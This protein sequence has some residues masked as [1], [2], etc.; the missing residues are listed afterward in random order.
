MGRPIK[1]GLVLG[2]Y[3]AAWLVAG[4]AVY[5]RQLNTQDA[6]AQPSAGMYAFGDLL[7]FL[8]VFGTLQLVPTGLA[9][10]FLRRWG[11]FWTVFSLAA[12]ALAMTG[13]VATLAVAMAS[14]QPPRSLCGAAAAFGVLRMLAAPLLASVLVLATLIAPAGRPRWGLWAATLIEVAGRNVFLL[15]LVRLAVC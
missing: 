14:T 7:L 15:P 13:L 8:F 2:G 4:A 9:L 11:P 10:C 1:L 5:V 12:V 3:A 6:D